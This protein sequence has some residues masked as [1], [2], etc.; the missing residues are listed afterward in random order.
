MSLKKN[1]KIIS[2][3][4][5][6][7]LMH[8]A[9]PFAST[10]LFKPYSPTLRFAAA[11][12]Q[13]HFRVG[14]NGEYGTSSTGKNGNSR[15]ANVLNI[16]ETSQSALAAL[17]QPTDAVETAGFIAMRNQLRVAAARDD[18]Q[19]GHI[20]LSGKFEQWD[21]TPHVTYTTGVDFMPGNISLN[22]A[23][24]MR[25]MRVHG[26]T[27]KELTKTTGIVPVQDQATHY[28]LTDDIKA[29]AKTFGN[30]DLSDWEATGIGD[31][32]VL[33]GWANNYPQ[34][35]DNLENVELHAFVGFT[36]P[37]AA[38]KDED[39]AFS[40]ALGNDGAWSLP[41]GLGLDLDFKNHIAL[42]AEAQFEVLFDDTK[43]RRIKTSPAQTEFLLFNK[44]R[45]T[46]DHGLTW[47][48]CLYGQAYHFLGGLSLKAAY[49]YVKHENDRLTPKSDSVSASAVNSSV[50]LHEW[51]MHHFIFQ[52]NYD[53]FKGLEKSIIKPQISF[54]YKL[55][56]DG[57]LV[58]AP[59]TF[60]GQVAFNF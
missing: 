51:N 53:F 33:L 34:T 5:I 16:F 38:Q 55:P 10:N 37:T 41:I 59:Q 23:V 57:K 28:L 26:I 6:A 17:E 60:G 11:P 18:G 14:A 3:A 31:V 35:K 30:L 46:K 29:K 4:T 20:A 56:V 24:P 7:A 49:E 39:K 15:R 27:R 43:V 44:T 42:G 22:V 1:K 54:F 52:M 36:A 47:R 50:R 12:K 40:I 25:G 13:C 2:I 45:V 21:V 8:T 48:F 32:A 9:Q 19:R 58:L